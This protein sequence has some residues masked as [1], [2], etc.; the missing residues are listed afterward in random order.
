MIVL[1]VAPVEVNRV[2]VPVLL[3]GRGRGRGPVRG[4]VGDD[5]RLRGDAG[6]RGNEGARNQTSRTAQGA[7][8]RVIYN[9]YAEVCQVFRRRSSVAVSSGTLRRASPL[10]PLSG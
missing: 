9:P 3:S 7:D 1:N 4:L 6:Q 10:A 8:H 5:R 2:A